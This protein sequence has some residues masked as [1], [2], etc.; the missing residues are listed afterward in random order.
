MI[1]LLDNY[2]SFTYNLLD[3][4]RQLDLE[5]EVV[6]NDKLDLKSLASYE[7]VVLSPGPGRPEGAGSCMEVIQNGIGK[8]PLLGICLGMQAIGQ[9]LG[10]RVVHSKLPMHGK[11]SEIGVK[12]GHPM[13]AHISYPLQVCR[14][15]SLVL[16]LPDDSPLQPVAWTDEEELMAVADE[17]NQV[18]GMQF[19]PEAILTTQG[20]QLLDNWARHFGLRKKE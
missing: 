5:V 4:L 20:L 3:Y 15:H 10:G 19:H 13:F 12:T 18:W 17:Q 2:D 1:L 14:Y 9:Y 8:V 16:Q 6:R 7:A 11:V